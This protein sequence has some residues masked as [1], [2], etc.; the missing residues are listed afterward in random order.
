MKGGAVR[1]E[2]SPENE[3]MLS[4]DYQIF[5]QLKRGRIV[6]FEERG[7]T[8]SLSGRYGLHKFE[9]Q[10]IDR[11]VQTHTSFFGGHRAIASRKQ[12][13]DVIQH[14]FIC[15]ISRSLHT[16]YLT[17]MLTYEDQV[18][19]P[20]PDPSA[21]GFDATNSP[22]LMDAFHETKT[23]GA[24]VSLNFIIV[25]ARYRFLEPEIYIYGTTGP[26]SAHT[27][28]KSTLR[29]CN[30]ARTASPRTINRHCC[31]RCQI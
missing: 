20:T 5:G 6:R 12:T 31:S 9:Q 30:I 27:R 18:V 25:L 23:K 26:T 16:M 21:T 24:S 7:P 10:K 17:Q 11:K 8:S 29:K 13:N 19:W 14:T 15:G 4:S 22:W 28:P 2:R 3:A 1:E